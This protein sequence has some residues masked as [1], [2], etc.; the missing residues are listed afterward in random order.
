[1]IWRSSYQSKAVQLVDL[2]T[3]LSCF[4]L[5]YY[6]A[7]FLHVLFPSIFPSN[8]EIRNSDFFIIF[9]I[10]VLIVFLFEKQKAYSYQRFT[11]ISKEYI[12]VVKVV[13]LAFLVM[14]ALMFLSGQKEMPR[15]IL[16]VYFSVNL[17]LF[18]IEK[19]L[20]FYEQTEKAL[21]DAIKLFDRFNYD[22]QILINNAMRFDKPIFKQ[23][24]LKVIESVL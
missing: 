16:S 17:I 3:A 4:P 14:I 19:T 10:S 18:L 7:I 12:I 1:M 15:T 2:L 11:S 8:L 21:T 24:I 5:T 22:K 13:Y 20:F 6:F 9:I 23:K